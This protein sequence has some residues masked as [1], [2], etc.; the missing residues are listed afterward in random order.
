MQSRRA[1]NGRLIGAS[2]SHQEPRV[3]RCSGWLLDHAVRHFFCSVERFER[4][5]NEHLVIVD[6]GVDEVNNGAG[7]K[8]AD[9]F[10]V[11]RV[12]PD[13]RPR[14]IERSFHEGRR[15]RLV[16]S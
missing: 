5:F 16:D 1:P 2:F 7:E 14:A 8:K 10:G 3:V 12:T 15:L 11:S 9:E 13:L 6:A 4:A